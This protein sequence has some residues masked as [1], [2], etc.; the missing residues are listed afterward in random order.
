M[1]VDTGAGKLLGNGRRELLLQGS[2]QHDRKTGGAP[3]NARL[4]QAGLF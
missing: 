2:D 3:D 4:V 1:D